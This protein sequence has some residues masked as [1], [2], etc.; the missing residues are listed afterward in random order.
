MNKIMRY[1][2]RN[3]HQCIKCERWTTLGNK[4]VGGWC[5]C[6]LID[7]E[8]E[9]CKQ[10][11]MVLAIRIRGEGD[12]GDVARFAGELLDELPRERKNKRHL[13]NALD[14]AEGM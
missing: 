3:K 14:V 1:L 9:I 6:C 4:L 12:F 11:G 13:W 7:L 10:I 2:R 5:L 8:S